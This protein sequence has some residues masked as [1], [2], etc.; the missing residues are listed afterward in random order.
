MKKFVI[1]LAA[2]GLILGVS[3]TAGAAVTFN[4]DPNDLLD[5][6][7]TD[8]T[9]EKEV[10]PNPRRLRAGGYDPNMRFD[11]F[12]QS[13]YAG[14][15]DVQPEEYNTYLNWLDSLGAQ[16]GITRFNMWCADAVPARSWGEVLVSKPGSSMS[17][18]ATDGWSVEVEENE[19]Y[20]TIPMAVWQLDDVVGLDKVLR[21]GGADI[22]LFS[23]S[24]DLYVDATGDGWDA[25]DSPAV[26]GQ[27]YRIWFGSGNMIYDNAGWGTRAPAYYD[28]SSGLAFEDGH[29][30]EGV[31]ELTAVP[32][33]ASV[34]VWCLLGAGSWLGMRV[35]RRRRI[36][37]GRQPWSNENRQAI[38]EI[39]TRH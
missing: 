27:D 2:V 10:Q 4:F 8:Y 26:L 23:F 16:E 12:L 17:A 19:W 14:D 11:T 24:G 29:V 13:S 31:L 30:W 15:P 38:H 35:W 34:L 22:G 25:G 28:S 20:P 32:E 39:V 18:T 3:G 33:P 6:Y 1:I 9:Q 21:P 7:G 37:V 5:L 36:P